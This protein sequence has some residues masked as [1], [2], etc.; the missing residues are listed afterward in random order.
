VEKP[1]QQISFPPFYIVDQPLDFTFDSD[2]VFYGL[3]YAGKTELGAWEDYYRVPKLNHDEE[4][5]DEKD[6]NEVAPIA[7]LAST[8]ESRENTVMRFILSTGFPDFQC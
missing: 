2:P 8:R 3:E 1:E 7:N 4:Y 6:N 5:F